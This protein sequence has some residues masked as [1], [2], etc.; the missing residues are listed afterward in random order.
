MKMNITRSGI[1]S[2]GMTGLYQP[3]TKIEHIKPRPSLCKMPQTRR[4]RTKTKRI[5]IL[6]PRFLPKR[7]E[8]VIKTRMYGLQS[9]FK[10]GE[11]F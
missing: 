7:M 10:I 5:H 8:N 2:C 9:N 4:N 11:R 1:F 6:F 3:F